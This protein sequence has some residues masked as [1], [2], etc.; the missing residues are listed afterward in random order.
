MLLG[1]FSFIGIGMIAA[2]LPLLYVERG[3]QMT[4]VLQSCLLLVSGVYYSIDVLP[5]WMQVLSHISPATYV[6]D[7][8]RK[9]LIDGAPVTALVGDVWPLLVMGAFLIP[10]GLWAFGRAERYAKTHDLHPHEEQAMKMWRHCLEGIEK[11]PFSLDSEIDWVIKHNLIE[12]YRAKHDI[13]LGHPRVALLDLQYHDVSRTRGVFYKL[14]NAGVVERTA[15]DA[16]IDTAMDTPPQTTRAKLRG[17]FIRRAKER[18]RDYTVDWVH[19]K[20]NDQAQRTVL[21]K[22]P[23]KAKDDRVDR[24]IA[25][26]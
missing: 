23:F 25:S 22:D 9:G 7:G 12:K 14:Q 16:E 8:V 13:P 3:A 15:T 2:I 11:D 21:C 17:D 18:R 1:S 6:L 4:F 19:L 10:F 5:G 26:L 20:V 24:L